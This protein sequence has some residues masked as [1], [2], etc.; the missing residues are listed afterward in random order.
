MTLGDL[1]ISHENMSDCDKVKIY[2]NSLFI[3]FGVHLPLLES[4]SMYLES[5]GLS[6]W[7]SVEDGDKRQQMPKFII[8]IPKGRKIYT[9]TNTDTHI[10]TPRY[11]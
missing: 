7:P 11:N 6:A 1:V 10:L 4:I 2:F 9:N 8:I 5:S 3:S